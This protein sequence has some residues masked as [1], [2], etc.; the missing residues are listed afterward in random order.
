MLKRWRVEV[1]RVEKGKENE[2][3]FISDRRRSGLNDNR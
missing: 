1:E 2:V 3:R